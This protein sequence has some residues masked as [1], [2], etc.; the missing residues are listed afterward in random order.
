[1][2]LRAIVSVILAL[3][4]LS[5]SV[6]GQKPTKQLRCGTSP[7]MERQE[8]FLHQRATERRAR[9]L[10]AGIRT[11]DG[12]GK[13]L[14][15]H[16]SAA[17]VVGDILVMRGDG[18]VILGRNFFPG[19]LVGRSIQFQPSDAAASAYRVQLTDDAYRTDAITGTAINLRSPATGF[20]IGDD[21]SREFDLPFPFPFYGATHTR[22]YVNSNGH[23]TLGAE[24]SLAESTTY[25]AFLSGPPKI[26]GASFDLDPEASPTDSG[27][28]VLLNPTEVIV[29]YVRIV[30]FG[31]SGSIASN[32][33][34]F[35][36]RFTPD[37]QVRIL[38]RSGPFGEFVV[39]ITPG[40]NRDF[41]QL[42]QFV[43]PPPDPISQSIAEIFSGS[44]QPSV[45]VFRASQVFFESQPDD[46]DYLVF[47][48][49]ANISAGLTAV[50]FEITVRNQV[51]GIGEEIVDRSSRFGSKERLQAIINMGPLSQYPDDP[52]GNVSVLGPSES[53]PLS[54]LAHEAG[55]RFLA[56][57]LLREGASDTIN[58]LGRQLAHWSFRFNSHGSFMEGSDLSAPPS[59]ELGNTY[60]T[61]PPTLRYSEFDRYL[62]GLISPQ[63]VGGE[64]SLFYVGGTGSRTIAPRRNE[65]IS[66]PR[67]DFSIDDIIAANG[68]RKP[69]HTIAQR[70]FRF[71]FVL[72]T[73]DE[74][75]AQPAL[76][77]L[78]R[79]RREFV[80][81]FNDRSASLAFADTALKPALG[82]DAYPATGVLAGSQA[83]LRVSRR[84][85]SGDV[86][87]VF[88][89][90]DGLLSLPAAATIPSGETA[91]SVPYTAL[92]PGVARVRAVAASGEYLPA[93]AAIAIATQGSLTLQLTSSA[94]V[95]ALPNTEAL[96]PIE[97]R[98]SDARGLP[99]EGVPVRLE[100][101]TGGFATPEVVTTD[102]QGAA[103][104]RWTVG[105]APTNFAKVFIEGERERT[106][107]T[108]AALPDLL[109]DLRAAT[110]AAS[111]A[112][113]VSPGSLATLF[114]VSLAGGVS[115]QA[116]STPLPT[117]MAGVQVTVN[118]AF[119][120]LIFISD[121]QINFFVPASV[122][123]ETA[124]IIVTTPDGK[125]NSLISPLAVYQ[126]G[127]FFDS[128]TN[129]GA[130]LR[131]GFGAK[132]DIV[133]ALPGGFVQIFATGLGPLVSAGRGVF[134]T[135]STVTVRIGDQVLPPD[136][137][138]FAGLAPGFTGLYQVNARIPE[139]LAP[140]NYPLRLIVEGQESNEVIV[141]VGAP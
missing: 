50:A 125:S 130:I 9:L 13:A 68:L 69:D 74:T 117:D 3:A 79:Y 53:S 104:F 137:G 19:A 135:L 82:M 28:F 100:P 128:G 58:L 40:G 24:D 102:A 45:D 15:L 105:D 59:G 111:F 115:R 36:I 89:G 42:I 34:D 17:S 98:V 91:V 57:P 84:G 81:F 18:G 52:Y 4:L 26:A 29:S 90:A 62:M 122:S 1:M 60:T 71:A 83:T 120:P 92:Q 11:V 77:K 70:R 30:R 23:L 27:I 55:H 25:S 43:S 106:E 75:K 46:Y 114:G 103:S 139:D 96:T 86:P 67:Q 116:S 80:Q 95:Q 37:G 99:Y 65:Q 64:Q 10:Q 131:N 21:D 88:E 38:H 97:V 93:E 48:N 31:T 76:E 66:G 101:T 73:E 78:D 35:Q 124:Q 138:D 85:T 87:L 112:G 136:P 2:N 49:D 132:T 141:I 63:Q 94:R 118:G 14:D 61:G 20:P 33:V 51:E 119:A 140:G 5:G 113:G 6:A 22:L 121:Q 54:V 32:L 56:F 39:G 107:L 44:S 133:P 108:V 16:R 129:L 110:N 7:A 123:G 126:P 12:A 41:G 134:R 47:Y 8:I 109:P 127:V 72:V